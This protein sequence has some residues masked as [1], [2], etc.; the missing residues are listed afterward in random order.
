MHLLATPPMPEL[1]EVETIRRGVLPHL[2]GRRIVDV[3]VRERRLRFP[4]DAGLAAALSGERIVEIGR[5]SKYLLM[6]GERHELLLHLGMSG[7]LFVLTE[8]LA[9]RRHDHVDLQ[10]DSGTLLRFHDPRRFGFISHRRL[11][12]PD[13]PFFRH[14]GP[15]PLDTAFDGAYLR[16][17][18]RGRTAPVKSLLMDARIVVGV[19]NIYAQEA[20]FEAGIRPRRAGG[21][22]GPG[23]CERLVAAVRDVLRR[24]IEAGGTTLRDFAGAD[25]APGYFQQDL[26]VYGRAGRPCRRCGSAIRMTRIAGRSSGWCPTCQPR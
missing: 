15:E 5:R 10:L 2:R 22:L 7:R 14:L 20:L 26:Y 4:V 19:G 24:A 3:T 21:R 12:G 9:A 23:D 25:G 16:A 8:P 6:R 11:D 18:L 13:F 17:K 1:P